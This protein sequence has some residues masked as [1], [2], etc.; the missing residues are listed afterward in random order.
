MLSKDI[1]AS[2]AQRLHEAEK[3]RK[4]IRQI[5]L[6]YPDITIEDAYAIQREW[7][8]LKPQRRS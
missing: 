3:S 6:D 7:L 5:S 8:D 1:I 2:C 4:Q